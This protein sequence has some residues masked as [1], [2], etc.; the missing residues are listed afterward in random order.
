MHKP[1]PH[2]RSNESF[3]PFRPFWVAFTKNAGATTNPHPKP[4]I[5]PQPQIVAQI[6]A[7][8]VAPPIAA[9][10]FGFVKKQL[11]RIDNCKHCQ[12]Q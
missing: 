9:P 12:M 8:I 11:S 1:Q 5:A 7:P 3:R 6:V 4:I 2:T 10:I